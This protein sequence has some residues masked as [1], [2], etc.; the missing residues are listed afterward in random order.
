MK[1][2]G[3][4]IY[5]EKKNDIIKAIEE[6]QV[7]QEVKI[8]ADSI[9]EIASQT[10]LLALN[11]AIEAARAGENGKGFALILQKVVAKFF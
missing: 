4:L 8:M 5:E 11:A 2:Q 9:G 7:V 1:R 6:G 3:N 10:N